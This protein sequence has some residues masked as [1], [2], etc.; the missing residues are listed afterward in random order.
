MRYPD[1]SVQLVGQ[2]GNAFF[3]LSRC[4]RAAQRGGLPPEEI[5][6]FMKEATADDYD[7][8]LATCMR[9]FDCH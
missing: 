1:I 2:D 9:W 3:I 8:L 7:H 5:D 6:A 4:K